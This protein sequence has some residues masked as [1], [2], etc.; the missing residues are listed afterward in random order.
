MGASQAIPSEPRS[1]ACPSATLAIDGHHS[2]KL[3]D[4]LIDLSRFDFAVAYGRTEADD[5]VG[6]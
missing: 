3:Y 1:V 2:E 4:S 5:R 6:G